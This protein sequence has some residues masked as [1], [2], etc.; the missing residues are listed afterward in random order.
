MGETPKIRKGPTLSIGLP[1]YNGQNYLDQA[2]AAVLGQRYTD[3]ELILCDN[4]S[5]DRTQAICEAFAAADPRVRY[6][7]S[8]TNLGLVRNFNRAFELSTGRYFKWLSHDD[9]LG[10]EFLQQCIDQLE[11]DPSLSV[12]CT[13]VAV[14]D[15]DGYMLETEENTRNN[16][17]DPLGIT[18]LR[19]APGPERGLEDGRVSHRHR[20]VLLHST[21]CYE[22]FGVIRASAIR[23]TPLRGY[24]PGSEKVFLTEL[25]L[26]GKIKVLPDIGMFMRVHD[27]R[28][29]SQAASCDRRALYLTP[30]DKRKR[31]WLPPQVRCAVGYAG[32][33]LRQPMPLRERLGCLWNIARFCLQFRKWHAV[34]RIAL[35]GREPVVVAQAPSRG[36]HALKQINPPAVEAVSVSSTAFSTAPQTQHA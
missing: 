36:G 28:L 14:I 31:S 33:V 7:R 16:R 3:F 13:S 30:S 12:C 34:C 24:Y 26:L 1:V 25:A 19:D 5:T 10:P 15:A 8:E 18:R 4:A 21:R 23:S 11:A 20:G 6:E 27:D 22:E 2:V 32:A 17:R 35:C 29:S 9:L